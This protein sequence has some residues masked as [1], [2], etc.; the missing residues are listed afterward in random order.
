MNTVP[1]YDYYITYIGNT[2][3][4]A[5][6]RAKEEINN[7]DPNRTPRLLEVKKKKKWESLIVYYSL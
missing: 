4:E 1:R 3:K 5:L 7:I 6:G 2:K